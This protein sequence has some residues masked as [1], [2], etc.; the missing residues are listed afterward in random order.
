MRDRPFWQLLRL[1]LDPSAFLKSVTADADGLEYNRRHRG[2]LLVYGRR[3]A[4]I[5]LVCLTAIAHFA[6]LAR[7]YPLLWIPLTAL[8]IGFSSG[9]CVSF[10][11]IASYFVLGLKR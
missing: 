10:V 1:Y 11:A 2:I 7:G 3:W 5:A 4:V 6:Y 8:E 9:L